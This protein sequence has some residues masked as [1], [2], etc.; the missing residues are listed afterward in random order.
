M[1]C[2]RLGPEE[3]DKV[4]SRM[5]GEAFL[6]E[7]ASSACR[8]SSTSTPQLHTEGYPCD[9]EGLPEIEDPRLANWLQVINAKLDAVIRMLSI[10][11]EGF[12]RLPF[13]RVNIGGGGL[14]FEAR[15]EYAV[16]DILEI[17]MMLSPHRPVAMYLC[18]EVTSI[19]TKDGGSEVAVKFVLIDDEVRDEIVRFV[20]EKEREILRGKRK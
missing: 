15:E 16:G 13:L 3:I 5:S 14:K 2:R 9:F 7:F 19:K 8:A 6:A 11:Q 17:K 10:Q 18:G 20:F 1:E 4:R 12:L